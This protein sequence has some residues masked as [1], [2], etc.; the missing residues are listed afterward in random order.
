VNNNRNFDIL[1]FISLFAVSIIVNY[2]LPPS[3]IYI[4]FFGLLGIF[5]LTKSQNNYFWIVLF[6][7]IFSTPGYLFFRL[8]IY[9]LPVISIFG[10]DRNV[11]YEELFAILVVIKAFLRPVNQTVFYRRPLIIIIL[12]SVFLLFMGLF[13]GI[14]ILTIL[15]SIRYFIPVLLLLVIPGLI[16][17]NC[18]PR[19]LLLMFLS[20]FVLVAAQLFD[21]IFGYPLAVVFGETQLFVSGSEVGTDFRAFDVT[22]GTVRTIYGPLILLFSLIMSIVLLKEGRKTYKTWF[23]YTV[24]LL[25]V[26]GIFMSASRGWI[27]AVVLVLTGLAYSQTRRFSTY[28]LSGFIIILL[29]FSVPRFNLQ[30]IKSFERVLTL[31]SLAKGD[32]T[33]EGSLTRITER[34]PRV[35]NKFWEQPVFG[36]GFSDEYYDYADGHVGNQTLL[37]NGGVVGY[38]IFLYFIF[39]ILYKYYSAF[40]VK[41]NKVMFVFMLGLL[42]LITIHSTS[43]MVFGYSLKVNSAISLSLFFFFSDYYLKKNN[44]EKQISYPS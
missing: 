33:A 24:S 36:F 11:F 17:Y 1:L 34:S 8:G 42:A 35:M 16:P 15:K 25:A 44:E 30:I 22:S 3:I 23:L 13:S 2:F 26:L 21:I 40:N 10:L 37:L 29:V 28:V 20:S 38:M 27:I 32:L 6:W 12:Y 19:I 18:I 7:L 41:K 4:W 14:G 39:F 9:H 5:F 31:E 43:S